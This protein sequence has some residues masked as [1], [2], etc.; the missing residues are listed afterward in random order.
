VNPIE[1]MQ[2]LGLMLFFGVLLT[3]TG[4][5]IGLAWFHSPRYLWAAA[6]TS[7]FVSAMGAWSIGGYLLVLTFILDT[8]TMLHSAGSMPSAAVCTG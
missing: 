1:L 4:V 6:A 3:L 8:V 2:V 5:F 7:W